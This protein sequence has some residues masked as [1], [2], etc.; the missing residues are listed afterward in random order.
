MNEFNQEN[1]TP[2]EIKRR[3]KNRMRNVVLLFEGLLARI[4]GDTEDV[5]D[6]NKKFNHRKMHSYLEWADKKTK[7]GIELKGFVDAI[8][9]EKSDINLLDLDDQKLA[10]D[11]LLRAKVYL[12]YFEG[13]F[14]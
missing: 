6:L 10:N 9:K 2:E 13:D 8:D 14:K 3:K 1:L 11:L 12:A 5:V 7:Q 4:E